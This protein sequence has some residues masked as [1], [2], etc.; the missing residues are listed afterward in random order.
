MT[1]DRGVFRASSGNVAL[2]RVMQVGERACLDIDWVEEPSQADR[3]EFRREVERQGAV[4]A[5]EVIA[6]PAARERRHREFF[7]GGVG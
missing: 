2:V 5:D 6:D 7:G 3:D 1:D 4:V